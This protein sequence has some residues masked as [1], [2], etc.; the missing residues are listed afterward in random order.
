MKKLMLITILLA[1]FGSLS[2]Q[3]TKEDLS[4]GID[5]ITG[6]P[7]VYT[8]IAEKYIQSQYGILNEVKFPK[9]KEYNWDSLRT[10]ARSRQLEREI[11]EPYIVIPHCS[12]SFP[13]SVIT[14]GPFFSRQIIIKERETF[15]GKE[16]IIE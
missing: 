13:S 8:E 15:L 4:K 7:A 6:M 1:I 14:T 16:Y 9:H 12:P 10:I 3:I 11:N 5:R 2:A